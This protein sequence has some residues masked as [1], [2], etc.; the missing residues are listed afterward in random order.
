ML[1]RQATLPGEGSTGTTQSFAEAQLELDAQ[2]PRGQV[3]HLNL[4]QTPKQMAKPA[5]M[6]NPTFLVSMGKESHLTS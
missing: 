5:D 6:Q 4:G 1:P 2:A 3:S